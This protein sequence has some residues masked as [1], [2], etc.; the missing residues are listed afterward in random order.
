MMDGRKKRGKACA[1]RQTDWAE[2]YHDLYPGVRAWFAARVAS[3]Q[4]ADDLAEKVLAKLV[5]KYGRKDLIAYLGAA[6]ANALHDYLRRAAREREF[7]QRLLKD[8][9]GGDPIWRPEARE[10]EDAQ[11]QQILDSLPPEQA[12]LLRL[13]YFDR[14]P[15]A[16]VARRVGCSRQAAYKRVQRL[17]QRLRD[18]YAAEPRAPGEEE[19]AENS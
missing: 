11:V 10:S 13:R 9:G 3:E 2:F 17:L 19:N 7:L 12:K 5:R 6:N 14:L 1:G 18:R 16:K 4:D 15:M 8:A